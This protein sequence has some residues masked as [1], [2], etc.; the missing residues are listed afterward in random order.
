MDHFTSDVSQ[1]HPHEAPGQARARL[2]SPAE[3]PT[4]HYT[5]LPEDTSHN[6]LAA[7]WNFYRREV[8]RLVGE[9][10]EGRWVLIQSDA[11]IGICDTEAEVDQVRL[12]K[13][14]GQPAL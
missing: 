4:L 13:F 6:P 9:G 14:P 1:Q 3:R 7:E 8:G 11:I 5:E 2:A 10:H 12:Q